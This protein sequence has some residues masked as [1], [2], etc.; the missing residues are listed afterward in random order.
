MMT[1]ENY[2]D[3]VSSDDPILET[4]MPFF[5]VS[6]KSKQEVVQ[7]AEILA[8]NTMKRN[9]MGLSAN[10]IGLPVRA[11][12]IPAKPVLVFFNPVIVDYS[13][14][15]NVLEEASP[16]LPG[17]VVKVKRP[18]SIRIRY[19]QPN[20]EIFTTKYTGMTSRVIQHQLHF[21]DGEKFY[22]LA[23]RYHYEQACK[24]WRK[25]KK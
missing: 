19:T 14:K 15:T 5:N 18:V 24:K 10:Q 6:N 25:M 4:P 12:C 20:G 2:R 1:E 17:F 16:T 13:S 3:L 23:S 9:L 8:F 22:C 11:L 21:L 7:I